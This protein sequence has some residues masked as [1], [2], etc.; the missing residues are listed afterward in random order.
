M[1]F[2]LEEEIF[3]INQI[4]KDLEQE[5]QFHNYINL[6]YIDPIDTDIH[7]YNKQYYIWKHIKNY[8]KYKINIHDNLPDFIDEPISRKNK[9]HI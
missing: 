7:I 3:F 2:T 8:K 1:N 4:N 5:E 9:I 6:S